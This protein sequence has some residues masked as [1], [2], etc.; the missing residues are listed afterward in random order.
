LRHTYIGLEHIMLGLIAEPGEVVARVFKHFV[1]DPKIARQVLLRELDPNFHPPAASTSAPPP[2]APAPTKPA[3]AK[4]TPAAAA[5]PP[6]KPPQP[7]SPVPVKKTLPASKPQPVKSPQPAR[8]PL[9]SSTPTS[10][11]T[12]SPHHRIGTVD[13]TRRFD[14]Y[15]TDRGEEVT[16]YRNARFK[17]VQQLFQRSSADTHSSFFEIELEAGQTVFVPQSSVIRFEE[18]APV[19][20]R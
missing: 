10:T 19:A 3:P 15:C 1:I 2:P 7:V 16:V 14:I 6:V 20:Q 8:A 5:S 17:S 11:K 12:T 13:I 9:A 4:S 18:C